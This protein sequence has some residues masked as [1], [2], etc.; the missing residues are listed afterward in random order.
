MG[1]PAYTSGA[2]CSIHCEVVRIRGVDLRILCEK[3][4]TVG[5]VILDRLA[6]VI[7]ERKKKTQEQVTSILANGIR[8]Q[9]NTRGGLNDGSR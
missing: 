4:P 3:H 2:I 6:A 5:K 9:G 7:A 8:Q 1:N